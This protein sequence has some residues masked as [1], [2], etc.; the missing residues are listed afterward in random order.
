MVTHMCDSV[1]RH[2]LAAGQKQLGEVAAIYAKLR[3]MVIAKNSR[4]SKM[5]KNLLA[6]LLMEIRAVHE[7]GKVIGNASGG[8]ISETGDFHLNQ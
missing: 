7:E 5:R 3:K 8:K 4:F 2:L 6:V 1:V